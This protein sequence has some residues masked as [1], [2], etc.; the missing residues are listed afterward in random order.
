MDLRSS[1]PGALDSSL[2]VRVAPRETAWA[3]EQDFVAGLKAGSSKGEGRSF[4]A[5]ELGLLDARVEY[6]NIRRNGFLGR[7]MVDRIVRVAVRVKLE[8]GG[9][10]RYREFQKEARDTV[11]VADIEHL[12]TPGMPMTHGSLPPQGFFDDLIEPVIFLGSIGVAV[13]LLF[14]VRS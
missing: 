5:C 6:D 4:E 10:T 14:A 2:T 11:A 3:L 8:G 13:Y 9:G 7:K 12:E 1:E